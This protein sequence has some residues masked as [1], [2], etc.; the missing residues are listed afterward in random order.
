VSSG[1]QVEPYALI[2]E[3]PPTYRTSGLLAQNCYGFRVAI[4]P[5]LLA[6]N[7]KEF[8][9]N[10]DGIAKQLSSCR[11]RGIFCGVVTNE[12]QLRYILVGR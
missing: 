6:A 1:F 12:C 4:G 10:S 2:P 8:F 11:D 9:C 5:A 3:I 7:S